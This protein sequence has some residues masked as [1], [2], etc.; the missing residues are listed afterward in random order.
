MGKDLKQERNSQLKQVKMPL[1]LPL[2]RSLKEVPKMTVYRLDKL[3]IEERFRRRVLCRTERGI[4][5]R[6]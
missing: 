6:D 3:I 1:S 4:L 2:P 5:R